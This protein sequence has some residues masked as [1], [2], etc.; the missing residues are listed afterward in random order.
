MSP[1]KLFSTFFDLF[2]SHM[3]GHVLR[4][5]LKCTSTLKVFQNSLIKEQSGH[6]GCNGQYH[7][8]WEMASC[9]VCAGLLGM[10]RIR[11]GLV[12]AFISVAALHFTSQRGPIFWSIVKPSFKI[13]AVICHA[14]NSE[15][16]ARNDCLGKE[17]SN[18]KISRKKDKKKQDLLI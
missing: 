15:K 14:Y 10:G 5:A 18:L 16:T 3:A 6:Y 11:D 7:G 13:G 1:C 8:H 12:V 4:H 17:E 9:M 2:V